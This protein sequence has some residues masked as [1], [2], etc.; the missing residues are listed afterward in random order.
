M[1]W[2]DATVSAV[3][4]VRTPAAQGAQEPPAEVTEEENT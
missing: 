2:K 3:E 4:P 1:A